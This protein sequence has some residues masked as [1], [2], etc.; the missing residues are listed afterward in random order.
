MENS[1]AW[2]G[3][4]NFDAEEGSSMFAENTQWNFSNWHEIP[5]K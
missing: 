1:V 2:F 5:T 3:I 4:E